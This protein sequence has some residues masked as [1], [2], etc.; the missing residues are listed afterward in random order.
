MP[1]TLDPIIV[2]VQVFRGKAIREAQ[3]VITIPIALERGGAFEY[4]LYR[5]HDSTPVFP[6]A[7][8]TRERKRIARVAVSVNK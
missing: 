5:S 6:W 3:L 8:C 4:N 1:G 7:W 2:N